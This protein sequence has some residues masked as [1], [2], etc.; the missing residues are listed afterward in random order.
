MT[1]LEV[2]FKMDMLSAIFTIGSIFGIC[3]WAWLHTKSGKRW[4]GE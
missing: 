2:V 1:V 4:L 3:F